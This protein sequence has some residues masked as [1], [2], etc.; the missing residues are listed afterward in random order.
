M[1][2]FENGSSHFE[3]TGVPGSIAPAALAACRAPGRHHAI[4]DRAEA[5]ELLGFLRG[6]SLLYGR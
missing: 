6:R 1:N 2:D 3:R 5:V 4:R